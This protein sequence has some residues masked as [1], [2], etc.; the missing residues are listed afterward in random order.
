MKLEYG[1]LL[2]Q[3]SEATTLPH[4]EGIMREAKLL[5]MEG[6]LSQQE[7]EDLRARFNNRRKSQQR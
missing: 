4:Q 1:Q 2:H 6:K 5:R 3:L 7:H